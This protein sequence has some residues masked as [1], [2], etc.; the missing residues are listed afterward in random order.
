[1]YINFHTGT[2]GTVLDASNFPLITLLS[3]LQ[4]YINWH[5]WKWRNVHNSYAYVESQDKTTSHKMQMSDRFQWQRQQWPS[6][7]QRW[8]G[9]T[10]YAVVTAWTV[11]TCL[12]TAE[13]AGGDPSLSA[14]FYGLASLWTR[15]NWSCLR[16]QRENITPRSPSPETVALGN[17]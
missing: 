2:N 3:S 6:A 11:L 7:F 12:Q 10:F 5:Y 1:M 16:A 13:A 17:V 8:D 9:A 4:D 14:T 15:Q